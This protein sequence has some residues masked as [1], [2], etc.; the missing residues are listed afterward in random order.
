[1]K[2]EY[3]MRQAENMQ[4]KSYG[5]KI[6]DRQLYRYAKRKANNTNTIFVCTLAVCAE[7]LGALIAY[8]VCNNTW[9]SIIRYAITFGKWN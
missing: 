9:Q 8:S 1:M 6:I 5:I 3:E 2:T 4:E 7:L